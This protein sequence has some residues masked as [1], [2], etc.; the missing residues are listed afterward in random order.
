MRRGRSA[1]AWADSWCF[2]LASLALERV[3]VLAVWR[4]G[5]DE[6]GIDGIMGNGFCRPSE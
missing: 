3:W 4:G 1:K 5:V 6:G 2:G